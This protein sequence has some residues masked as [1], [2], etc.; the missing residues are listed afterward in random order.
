MGFGMD[1]KQEYQ[2]L[3]PSLQSLGLLHTAVIHHRRQLGDLP[4]NHKVVAFLLAF[5]IKIMK[6]NLVHKMSPLKKRI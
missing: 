4:K 6:Q 1:M 3:W 5:W 2:M